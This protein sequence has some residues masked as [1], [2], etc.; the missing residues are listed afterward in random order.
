MS[1]SSVKSNPITS[2]AAARIQSSTAKAN[3]GQV[4]ANSFAARAQAAA[5]A[6]QSVTKGSK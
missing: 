6:N 5:A 4:S 2:Q 3:G 1:K